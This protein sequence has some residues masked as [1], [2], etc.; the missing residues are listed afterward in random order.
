MPPGRRG[1]PTRPTRPTRPGVGR[2]RPA[3]GPPPRRPA[4][5][6]HW[7]CPAP[8]R[9]PRPRVVHAGVHPGVGDRARQ[10][11]EREGRRREGHADGG[12]EGDGR[13]GVARR[14]RRRSRH[15]HVPVHRDPGRLPVRPGSAH[16]ALAEQVGG[17]GGHGD[18]PDA[19]QGRPAGARPAEGE[20]AGDAEPELGVVGGVGDA[21]QCA[22]QGGGRGGGHR[23]VQGAV[24]GAQVA[25]DRG[26]AG[27]EG[28]CGAVGRSVH[29][30]LL[31]RAG[32]PGCAAA[33]PACRVP[34]R[35]APRRP[36]RATPDV[37]SPRR[38]YPSRPGGSAP[39]PRSSIAGGAD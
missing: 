32:R 35:P 20:R 24:H 12:G 6:P 33:A 7:R 8:H 16:Q 17:G 9:R 11:A 2:G 30:L 13:R 21:A 37:S 3:A 28:G 10:G 22:V 5:P 26:E 38:P 18:R 14:E 31:H 29:G 23:G 39:A 15:R 19:E 36:V 4:R 27:G 25:Q 1:R 34:R